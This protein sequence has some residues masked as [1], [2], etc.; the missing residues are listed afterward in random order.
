MSIDRYL[1][2][3]LFF[4][5]SYVIFTAFLCIKLSVVFQTGGDIIRNMQS[6]IQFI[7]CTLTLY[8]V[9]YSVRQKHHHPYHI[10]IIKRQSFNTYFLT[11]LYAAA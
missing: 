8:F 5:Y 7:Q 10:I 6:R 2:I 4:R 1:H 3:N 11:T 9:L